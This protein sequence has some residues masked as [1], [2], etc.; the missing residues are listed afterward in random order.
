M[1]E[2]LSQEWQLYAMNSTK[3]IWFMSVLSP[4]AGALTT[5]IAVLLFIDWKIVELST[6]LEKYPQVPAIWVSSNF[7][8][9]GLLFG[10]S[11]MPVAYFTFRAQLKARNAG[12]GL[13]DF[14]F[15]LKTGFRVGRNYSIVFSMFFGGALLILGVFT[16]WH[17]S[18]LLEF[19][20]LLAF[21]LLWIIGIFLVVWTLACFSVLLGIPIAWFFA[22]K[23]DLVRL[24]S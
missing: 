24:S 2:R 19:A 12:N 20:G 9:V 15:L 4:I 14:L 7:L 17:N 22:K 1:S 16:A 13:F 21:G 10:V 5:A 23:L 11:A 18:P 3:F 6:I 8:F